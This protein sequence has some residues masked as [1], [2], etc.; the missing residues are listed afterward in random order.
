MLRSLVTTVRLTSRGTHTKLA[1]PACPVVRVDGANPSNSAV[2][3]AARLLLEG[4]V[5]A[6]PT[7]TLYGVAADARNKQAVR[8][9][10][11]VKGRAERK[12]LAIC[13][14]QVSQVR[15]WAQVPFSDELLH[16]LLPGPLT[17]LLRPSLERHLDL[18]GN[19]PLV[20]VRVPGLEFPC[21]LADEL[22][23]PLALTSANLSGQPSALS[24]DEFQNLFPLLQA[25]FDGGIIGKGEI[26]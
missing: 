3:T 4:H 17:L 8:Q 10:Y 18:P 15:D 25:V 21:R 5:V 19:P 24:I 9:L 1:D 13:L 7:D 20:G 12:A 26:I 11:N 6:L 2:D 14:G 16:D 22:G 23:G